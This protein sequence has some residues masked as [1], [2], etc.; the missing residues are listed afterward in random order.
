[1]KLFNI[2]FL[3][4]GPSDFKFLEYRHTI[5][6]RPYLAMKPSFDV[7]HIKLTQPG[8]KPPS[9]TDERFFTGKHKFFHLP[10]TICRYI[11]REA[12]EVLMVHG[13]IFPVQV[14]VLR[15]FKP[16]HTKLIIQHH[17]EKP[18]AHPVKRWFQKI[19]YAPADA[20]LFA[21]LALAK[22]YLEA[23]IITDKRRLH[24]VMEGSTLFTP[25]SKAEAR[26][27][28]NIGK[29]PVFL[30]VGRLNANKDPLTVLKAM[31]L[32]K[33]AGNPFKFYMIYG[34]NELEEQVR[35]YIAE[36]G[37]QEHVVLIG[38]TDHDRLN[39]WY[40]A[41]DYFVAASYYEGSGLALCEAMACGCIPIVSD[42]ASF[43]TM[44]VQGKYGVLFEAGNAQALF[45]K[46]SS[47]TLLDINTMRASVIHHF[48]EHLSGEAI[49]KRFLAIARSVLRE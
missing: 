7:T 34:S 43:S 12:P 14:L 33:E 42:I 5:D 28:L 47:L 19:A 6:A 11:R 29:E 30:W 3:A 18:F 16:R 31:Y 24:E 38:K 20:F 13:F 39:R 23:G 8:F 49:G 37:L 41:A 44:T 4:I 2:L 48:Q 1:M 17:A 45:E 21:S 25:I 35:H 32:F 10:L 22:P 26:A 15:W 36:H 27:A 40:S 9:K 46:L